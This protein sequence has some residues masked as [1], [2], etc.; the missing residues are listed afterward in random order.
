M[1]FI[2]KTAIL[3]LM[4]GL[5]AAIVY[6]APAQDMPIMAED[7]QKMDSEMT[8]QT[9][10]IWA[11]ILSRYLAAHE[12]LNTFDYA[13][14]HANAADMQALAD[15]IDNLAAQS[16]SDMGA[17]ESMAYWANLYNA[18]TVR[19]VAQNYPVGSIRDIKSGLFSIGPWKK[20]LVTVE[21]KDLTL[22]NIED[23]IMRPAYK[24]PMVHYMV[25]CASIGCPNLKPTP[26]AAKTLE[27]DQ[28]AAA[29]AFINSSR[30][31]SIDKKGR[32]KVSSIYKWFK[33]DFDST[34]AGVLAHLSEYAD[35][36]LKAAL[37][38]RGEIDKYDYNWRLN[39][40]VTK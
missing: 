13:G 26:W 17:Q 40:P 27:A 33:E 35:A 23:D 11:D 28:I 9:S 34:E 2:K 37:A 8:E 31:V 29:K 4:L 22:D 30:G 6:P 20:K 36:D 1:H 32:V 21:G 24:T 39:A 10:Q 19:I 25:N 14:L 3:P 7:M 15:Y 16:P 38:A 18:L 5:S 12:G